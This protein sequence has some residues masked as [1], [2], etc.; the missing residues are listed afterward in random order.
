M[1]GTESAAVVAPRVNG[2]PRPAPARPDEAVVRAIRQRVAS[3]LEL[4]ALGDRIAPDDSDDEQARTVA[5]VH[6]EVSEWVTRQA[7]Q[8]HA[9]PVEF[10]RTL[11][12]AVLAALAGLGALKPLLEREDVENIHIHGNDRVFL[13]LANGRLERWPYP[14]AD[15]DAH[16]VEMLAEFASRMGQ[17]AREFSPASPM[18]NLRLPTG[19]PLGTRLAAVMEV[20]DRPRVAIRRH[21]LT[22]ARLTEFVRLGTVDE[23]LAEFLR[24]S[25][26]AGLN[27]IIVGGPYAGKTSLLRAL[28]HE[29]PPHEHIITVEDDFEL[30]LHLV[31]DHPLVTPLE[32]RVANA[33]RAGEVT[34]DDL[35]RQALRHSPTRVIVGEV[36]AG[37]V[38]SM[39][40]AL[41]NGAAGGMC[42][43]HAT[44]AMATFD[45][46]AALGQLAHPPL[47]IDAAYR[48][49]AS[50]IDLV[51]HVRKVDRQEAD[52]ERFVT[53][54]LEVGPVGD[55]GRPDVTRL[56][57]PRPDGR[58][59]P[60]LPPSPRLL[61]ELQRHGFD[62]TLF[63]RPNGAWRIR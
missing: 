62:R 5:Y 42:T 49:T 48:W 54:V 27:M 23:I 38:T 9:V 63:D 6:E 41:G 10:E 22:T 35:L 21:R 46:I 33:E 36:R 7:H 18:V 32:A 57:T 2:H 59:V 25:V 17:T 37:E 43:L 31:G 4:A 28:A 51:V 34:L 16:L 29:I 13:E 1:S 39:L 45:R 55:S 12:Q 52:R 56:F 26:R 3:R 44:S 11:V 8:G 30:G 50:A 53:E 15:T 58:A 19:G 14:I 60:S 61:A 24:A 20:T 40:R 47:A